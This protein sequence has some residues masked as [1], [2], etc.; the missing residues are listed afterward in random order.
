MLFRTVIS[1][2]NKPRKNV[3]LF[4]STVHTIAVV[5]PKLVNN[6]SP[7]LF[8]YFSI[9]HLWKTFRKRPCWCVI[10]NYFAKMTCM[11]LYVLSAVSGSS[12]RVK[13]SFRWAILLTIWR[14]FMASISKAEQWCDFPM[15]VII[16]KVFLSAFTPLHAAA[17]GGK[18]GSVQC[19]NVIF[20]KWK[21]EFTKVFS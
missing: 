5:L 1:F 8:S 7:L 6:Y 14:D 3:A 13:I 19:E 2:A 10:C 20:S 9:P 21:L 4:H 16:I 15:L 11:Y 17:F 12:M 18:I